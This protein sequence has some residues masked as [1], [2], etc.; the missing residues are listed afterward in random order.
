MYTSGT[1]GEAKGVMLTEDNL[2]VDAQMA[3][4]RYQFEPDTHQFNFLPFFYV[5]GRT[6]D[7]YVWLLGGHRLTLASS[8]KKAVEEVGV[9]APTHINGVPHF[10][11]KLATLCAQSS[12]KDRVLGSNLSQINSGG[13]ALARDVFDF[14]QAN[15]IAVLEGY[16]LTET[17]PV[18]TLTG[19]NDIRDDSVGCAIEGTEIKLSEDG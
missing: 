2:V 12:S 15:S 4:Q 3:L 1:T 16:G 6:C 9:I 10:F 17:S 19:P 7:L 5:F 11:Q 8:R 13:S 18:A 14:Y